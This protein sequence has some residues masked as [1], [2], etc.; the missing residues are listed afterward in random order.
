MS[1]ISKRKVVGQ[2]QIQ[3]RAKISMD[4]VHVSD[5]DF[6]L[7]EGTSNS[8]T[9]I[10]SSNIN[11]SHVSALSSDESTISSISHNDSVDFI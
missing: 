6:F 1:R 7:E 10:C 3:K 5:D 11:F 9:T 2:R 8:T 4:S